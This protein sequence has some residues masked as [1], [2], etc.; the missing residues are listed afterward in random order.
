MSL[1]Q[2]DMLPLHT[3]TERLNIA[4]GNIDKTIHVIQHIGDHFSSP[5]TLSPVFERA[6]PASDEFLSALAKISSSITFLETHREFK[7]SKTTLERAQKVL[8][9]ALAIMMREFGQLIGSFPLWIQ[10]ND[11]TIHQDVADAKA[12]AEQLMRHKMKHVHE[13]YYEKR[14]II[15]DPIEYPSG[16]DVRIQQLLSLVQVD[17]FVR[18]IYYYHLLLRM[19][20]H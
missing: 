13:V 8:N 4:Q 19:R 18:L 20:K 1:L 2:Q 11:Q 7:S 17:T 16:Y 15:L 9:K 6:S 5:D 14:M 12:L 10:E 3:L